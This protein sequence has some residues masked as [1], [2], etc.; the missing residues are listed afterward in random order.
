MRPVFQSGLQGGAGGGSVQPAVSVT[1]HAG[2]VVAVSPTGNNQE[3]A[4]NRHAAADLSWRPVK[5]KLILTGNDAGP[6]GSTGKIRWSPIGL[7]TYTDLGP[8]SPD[9]STLV[10]AGTL[11]GDWFDIDEDAWQD[12]EL[13][14]FIDGGNGTAMAF[15]SVVLVLSANPDLV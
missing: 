7:G 9:L 13:A 4:A 15:A 3:W 14:L 5:G 10:S 11:I 12:C 1:I 8:V 2:A 6:A